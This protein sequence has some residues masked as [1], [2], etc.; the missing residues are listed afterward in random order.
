MAVDHG[1]TSGAGAGADAPPAVHCVVAEPVGAT[2]DAG[3]LAGALSARGWSVATHR[4]H[5][6]FPRLDASAIMAADIL[7]ARLPDHALVAVDGEAVP[8]LAGAM[9]LDSHRLRVVVLL[10][11]LLSADPGLSPME[12]GALRGIEQGAL[13]CARRVLVPDAA[14]EALAA[15]LGVAPSALARVDADAFGDGGSAGPWVTD[16]AVGRFEDELRRAAEG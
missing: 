9:R 6:R 3:A 16:A 10:R 14:T 1:M 7:M 13:V 2:A 15:G 11:G 12:A 8:A 4:L 5:G